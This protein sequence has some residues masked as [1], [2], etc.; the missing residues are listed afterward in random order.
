MLRLFCQIFPPGIYKD[1]K[2]S[3]IIML[4]SLYPY[5]YSCVCT[6]YVCLYM[7]VFPYLLYLCIRFVIYMYA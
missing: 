5:V 1:V 2:L 6:I 3:Q 7:C 4:L